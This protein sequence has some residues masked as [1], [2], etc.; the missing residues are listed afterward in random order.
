MNSPYLW[1]LCLPKT[2]ILHFPKWLAA[3]ID[4]I[5]KILRLLFP[6]KLEQVR[7]RWV[8]SALESFAGCWPSLPN[9][10]SRILFFRVPIPLTRG[11]IGNNSHT[12]ANFLLE[13]S[14]RYFR[15]FLPDFPSFPLLKVKEMSTKNTNFAISLLFYT[16]N[17]ISTMV[18][19]IV[20]SINFRILTTNWSLKNFQL[21]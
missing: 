19:S 12:F 4:D 5:S 3:R 7:N 20:Q 15:N 14:S 10:F 8:R 13:I 6:A 9:K 18:I 16:V 21:F 17:V 1:F 11:R 2:S